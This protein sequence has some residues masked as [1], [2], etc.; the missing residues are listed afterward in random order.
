MDIVITKPLSKST[1]QK[2]RQKAR[3][4]EAQDYRCCYCGCELTL[5]NSTFDHVIPRA[6]GGQNTL[7]NK[8]ISCEPC[9]S[10][11]ADAPPKQKV[12][13]LYRRLMQVIA[14]RDSARD[15]EFIVIEATQPALMHVPQSQP[16]LEYLM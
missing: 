6:E 12:L 11:F 15:N 5:E 4:L 8:V 3:A 9:N 13:A 1:R 10:E 14:E 2:L 16:Q 7:D